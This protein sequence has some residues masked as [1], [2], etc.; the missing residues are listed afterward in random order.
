MKNNRDLFYERGDPWE[1][2]LPSRLVNPSPNLRVSRSARIWRLLHS[3]KDTSNVTTD[4]RDNPDIDRYF[5]D[6]A[7]P[8]QIRLARERNKLLPSITTLEAKPSSPRSPLIAAS[9][10]RRNKKASNL[11]KVK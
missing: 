1:G 10:R 6:R 8:I 9:A 7:V 5:C 3:N 2:D 4:T 11:V